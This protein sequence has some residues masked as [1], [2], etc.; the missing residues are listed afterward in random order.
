MK[1]VMRYLKV[2]QD[3]CICFDR[4]DAKVYG[5]FDSNYAG[6]LD[7]QKSTTNYVFTFMGG[8]VS[9][10]S[11]MQRCTAQSTT[12]VEYVATTKACK[13]ALWL[14]RLVGDLGCTNDSPLLHCGNQS[15]IQLSQNPIFHAKTKHIDM[16][17]HFIKEVIEEKL[18]QLVKI[19]IDDNPTI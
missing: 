18:V 6:H 1:G 14:L 7:N 16:K 10:I 12:K 4:Q 2:T 13:Q 3:F 15:A 9:W 17:N 11:R 8:V 5:F 19:Y